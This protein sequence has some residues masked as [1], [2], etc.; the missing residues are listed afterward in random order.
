MQ[1]MN[2]KCIEFQISQTKEMKRNE[3]KIDRDQLE[4]TRG[5]CN[6]L[7]QLLSM[8]IHHDFTQGVAGWVHCSQC[9]FS[10]ILIM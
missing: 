3:A 7:S 5:F 9:C 8:V 4:C 6:E 2:L 1:W 10:I